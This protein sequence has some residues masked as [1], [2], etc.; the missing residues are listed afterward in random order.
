MAL[1]RSKERIPR[2]LIFIDTRHKS[3]HEFPRIVREN[4]NNTISVYSHHWNET[5]P[6]VWFL[7]NEACHDVIQEQFPELVPYHLSETFGPYKSD[8]C[9]AAALHQRGGYYFDNDLEVVHAM[10]IPNVT[11]IMP[12]MRQ[13][14]EYTAPNTFIAATPR[15]VI[16]E[17]TL[18]VNYKEN[19]TTEENKIM[20]P[21]N[22]WE[23][24]VAATA[25]Y[26]IS[27][28]S[29]CNT[30]WS[31]FDL[32]QVNLDEHDELYPDAPRRKGWGCC[33][34]YVIHHLEWRKIYF[35]SRFLGSS[36]SCRFRGGKTADDID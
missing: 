16:I 22:L 3:I 33:C 29:T 5:Q 10:T 25:E 7:G 11:F 30:T 15:H 12:T 24:Y 21:I 9:R 17:K 18:H 35:W 8:I 4:I 32:T 31:V 1:L 6:K 28:S 27:E 13:N 14:D 20:G 23:G 26:C 2:R 36:G 19:R 34:N